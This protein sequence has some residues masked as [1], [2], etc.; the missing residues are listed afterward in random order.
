[1]VAL[2]FL[3]LAGLNL[4]DT[5]NILKLRSV[6][7]SG[8]TL[9]SEAKG[10]RDFRNENDRGGL[11]YCVNSCCRQQVPLHLA[12]RGPSRSSGTPTPGAGAEVQ[13][14]YTK[15]LAQGSASEWRKT[16]PG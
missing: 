14:V 11:T 3:A 8:N 16:E 5:K 4:E 2:G 6:W 1:M 13:L 10:S 9:F 7:V 12:R 15:E